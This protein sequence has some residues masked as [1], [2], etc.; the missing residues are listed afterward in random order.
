MKI[1]SVP[2][3]F[4][5]VSSTLNRVGFT[6]SIRERPPVG[7]ASRSSLKVAPSVVIAARVGDDFGERLW[8]GRLRPRRLP[9][10]DAELVSTIIEPPQ[11]PPDGRRSPPPLANVINPFAVRAALRLDAE[12]AVA[13]YALRRTVMKEN[14]AAGFY[15]YIVDAWSGSSHVQEEAADVARRCLDHLEAFGREL[16]WRTPA[17]EDWEAEVLDKA[18]AARTRPL[19]RYARDEAT[20]V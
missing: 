11:P 10:V 13:I 15:T 9:E 8:L 18:L 1:V 5:L 16:G 20:L 17:L 12:R 14:S 3:H 2:L 7:R 4:L 6:S 19:E